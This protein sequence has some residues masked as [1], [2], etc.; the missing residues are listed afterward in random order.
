MAALDSTTASPI[1]KTLYPNGRVKK[2]LYPRMPG[3]AMLKKNPEYAGEGI[4][5]PIIHEGSNG[6]SATFSTALAN[7]DGGQMGKFLVDTVEDYSLASITRKVMLQTRNDRGARLKAIELAFNLAL[8]SVGRSISHGFYRDGEGTLGRISTGSSVGTAT[9]TLED[10]TDI[11]HIRKGMRLQASLTPGS[12]LRT[13]GAVVT[14]LSVNRALG[15]ITATGNWTAGIAGVLAGDYIYREG[16]ARNAGAA[17][18]Q[19]KLR[20]LLAWLPLVDPSPSENFFGQ[21]RSLDRTRMAGFISDKSALPFEEALIEGQSE[22]NVESLGVDTMLCNNAVKRLAQKA[23]GSK[24][25]WQKSTRNAQDEKGSMASIGFETIR[26]EGDK[27]PIDLV[28]D[29]DCPAIVPGDSTKFIAFMLRMDAWTLYSMLDA[30]H[31][32]D[33]DTD[34][35]KLREAAADAYEGRTGAYLNLGPSEDDSG[36]G[37]SGIVLLPSA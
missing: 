12:A 33:K 19:K 29:P 27:G 1:L 18:T 6:A 26:L 37:D 10:K 13:S 17:N 32:F 34:Q 30:P 20:G 7:K 16:D 15:T 4:K 5:I 11:V 35:E 36:P 23:C 22:I 8:Y 14:V 31:I 28:A 2:Q 21:D 3:V 25:T 24:V 9:I